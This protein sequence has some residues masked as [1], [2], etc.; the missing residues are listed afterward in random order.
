M[1]TRPGIAT[2]S[3]IALAEALVVGAVLEVVGVEVLEVVQG[4]VDVALP[5]LGRHVVDHLD[6]VAVGVGEVR[7]VGHPVVAA[8]DELDA[9][10]LHVAELVEPRLAVRVADGEVVHADALAGPST[11]RPGG[12]NRSGIVHLDQ[13]E[14]VVAGLVDRGRSASSSC[15]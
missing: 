6:A 3:G 11:N 13:G 7:R 15:G 4:G 9:V 5:H 1:L 14:V 2:G 10:G 12:G 8:A